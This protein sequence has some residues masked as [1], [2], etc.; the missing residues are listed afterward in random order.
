[1]AP[2]C[3]PETASNGRSWKAGSVPYLMVQSSEHVR[4]TFGKVLV[5]VTHGPL[6]S[7][8]VMCVI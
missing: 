1:M 2:S 8:P 7:I 4:M 5:M 3:W 6:A